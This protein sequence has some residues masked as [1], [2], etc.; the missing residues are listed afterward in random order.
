MAS[1]GQ[2]CDKHIIGSGAPFGVVLDLH[3][4]VLILGLKLEQEIAIDVGELESATRERGRSQHR[5]RIALACLVNGL[6]V[7]ELVAQHLLS[8]KNQVNF[9]MPKQRLSLWLLLMFLMSFTIIIFRLRPEPEL[10]KV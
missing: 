9:L 8:R 7:D 6:N 4:L 5:D 1:L 10:I 2:G 3:D